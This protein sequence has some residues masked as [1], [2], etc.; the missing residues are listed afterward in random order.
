MSNLRDGE[1]DV[2]ILSGEI[3]RNLADSYLDADDG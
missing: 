2:R 1:I 3:K